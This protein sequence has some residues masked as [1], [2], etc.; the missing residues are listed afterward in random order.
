MNHFTG[1]TAPLPGIWQRNCADEF[2]SIDARGQVAQ[3]DCWVLSYPEYA[4][5]NVFETESFTE[6]LE[7]SPARK[8]FHARPVRLAW[9]IDS[10]VPVR[11]SGP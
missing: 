9:S 8:R 11:S 6:L 2:V 1:R 7:T 5:G 4:F 3:C 10:T